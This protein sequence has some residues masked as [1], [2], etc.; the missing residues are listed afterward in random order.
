[1]LRSIPK[2]TGSSYPDNCTSA[3]SGSSQTTAP[4]LVLTGDTNVD[5]SHGDSTVQQLRGEPSVETHWQVL[6]SGAQMRGDN[7]FI[8]GAYG[9]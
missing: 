8:K 6:T 9:K 3:R 5:K 1:M 7:L 2:S 4:V